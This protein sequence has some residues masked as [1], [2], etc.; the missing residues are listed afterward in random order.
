MRLSEKNLGGLKTWLQQITDWQSRELQTRIRLPVGHY[1]DR[2]SK[3]PS[4]Q[5]SRQHFYNLLD[6]LLDSLLGSLLDSL[7]DDLLDA[8][9]KKLLQLGSS[10]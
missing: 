8:R 4:G 2:A 6:S 5:P 10:L 1:P 3:Q 7:L 9:P